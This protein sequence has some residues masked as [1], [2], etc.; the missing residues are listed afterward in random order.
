[1]QDKT[2]T[3]SWTVKAG[4]LKTDAFSC[5][6]LLAFFLYGGYPSFFL[7][8]YSRG[9]LEAFPGFSPPLSTAPLVPMLVVMFVASILRRRVGGIGVAS[10]T[11]LGAIGTLG[12]ILGKLAVDLLAANGPTGIA[13]TF[14]I[15]SG[16]LV[17]VGFVAC[18][19]MW[20]G[21]L[22]NGFGARKLL[23]AILAYFSTALLIHPTILK[24][25]MPVLAPALPAVS[26]LMWAASV[27]VEAKAPTGAAADSSFDRDTLK[28]P[29]LLAFMA[30]LTAE[31]LVRGITD[32]SPEIKSAEYDSV[33]RYL[34]SVAFFTVLLVACIVYVHCVKKANG[35][36]RLRLQSA[37]SRGALVGWA[38]LAMT[39]FIGS[40]V[41]FAGNAGHMGSYLITASR[42]TLE[43]IFVVLL[44]ATIASRRLAPVSACLLYYMG[45]WWLSYVLSY[46]VIP[47]VASRSAAVATL[48][49]DALVGLSAILMVA[50]LSLAFAM[51]LSIST[52]PANEFNAMLFGSNRLNA[53]PFSTDFANVGDRASA[54][55]A[56]PADRLAVQLID[57]WNLTAREA[58]VTLYFAQG[59]S[60]GRVSEKLGIGKGTAQGYI[61][62]SYRKL[63]IHSKD[64]LIQLLAGDSSGSI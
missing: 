22:G 25:V 52:Q 24:H 7:A 60:L 58:Q 49:S 11:V 57:N 28:S 18:T 10:T 26:S 1:M 5:L 44:A 13:I 19:C 41:Y 17:A 16:V 40:V 53:A 27:R 3:G 8:V 51:A 47:V 64:E 36:A 20:I 2:T 45:T 35:D 39:F 56:A 29:L 63:G 50:A 43:A 46:A 59:F 15:A 14:L 6:G 34:T 37:F 33:R 30:F 55:L 61:R 21:W 62:N 38:T 9:N 32:W 4:V 31:S 12:A 54:S 42:S 48:S 23:L